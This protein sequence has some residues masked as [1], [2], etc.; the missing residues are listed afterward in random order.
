MAP[1]PPAAVRGLPDDEVSFSPGGL[2]EGVVVRE[3]GRARSSVRFLAYSFTSIPIATAMAD[4]SKRG[5]SVA[6]VVDGSAERGNA[7]AVALMR[8]AGVQVRVDRRH[9]IMHNK[10][11]V[12]DAQTVLNGSYNYSKAANVSNAENLRIRRNDPLAGAYIYDW[13]QHWSHGVLPAE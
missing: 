9:A 6:G 2:T 11:I 5:V 8:A 12:V 7:G 3:V 13:E 1:P 10:V 4:A